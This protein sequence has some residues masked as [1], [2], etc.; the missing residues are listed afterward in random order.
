[1]KKLFILLFTVIAMTG[2]GQT[3][4][5][6]FKTM[7]I[8]LLPGFSE[9]NKVMLLVDT[10][11]TVIPY[12]LGEIEKLQYNRDYLKIKTS[13]IGTTQ[14][15]LLPITPDST[16]VCVIKTV[17]GSACDSHIAFYTTAWEKTDNDAF[18]PEISLDFFFDSSQKRA[19]NHKYAVS[20]PDIYPV[21]A[22]FRS[23]NNDLTLTLDYKSH[24]SADLIAEFESFLKSDS[25]VLKWN[26]ASFR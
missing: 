2:Y 8:G 3:I 24:L 13:D 10:G 4:A 7:P 25:I 12:A 19:E 26:N 9:N 14:I 11:K 20:L 23:G 5:D 15:K 1:M 17:C 6:V 18:L 22:E 21:Y 16:I